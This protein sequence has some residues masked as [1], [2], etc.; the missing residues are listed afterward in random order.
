MVEGMKKTAKESALYIV[1]GAI[2][3]SVDG[4]FYIFFT[5]ALQFWFLSGEFLEREHRRYRELFPKRP[6]Q[7]QKN[8]AAFQARGL[9]LR[10]LLFWYARIDGHTLR[11]NV[12]L[13]LSRHTDKGLRRYSRGLGAVRLQ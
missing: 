2:A 3:S 4:L 11:G 5:R 1:I 7:F 8:A 6:R 10:G 13:R 9:V 12:G